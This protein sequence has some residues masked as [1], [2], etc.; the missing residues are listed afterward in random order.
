M[1]SPCHCSSIGS[2]RKAASKQIRKMENSIIPNKRSRS[3]EPSVYEYRELSDEEDEEDEEDEV[4]EDTL[5]LLDLYK[6]KLLCREMDLK[7][8]KQK[9]FMKYFWPTEDD[10]EEEDDEVEED[11]EERDD[12]EED[13]EEKEKDDEEEEDEKDDEEENEKDD[14]EEEEKD[15]EEEEE[16]DD[17]EDEKEKKDD[18]EEYD[19]EEEDEEERV[20]CLSINDQLEI[21]NYY[22]GQTYNY[23]VYCGTMYDSKTDYKNKCPGQY[24]IDHF[25]DFYNDK[26]RI[27]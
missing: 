20:Y 6:C 19:E 13:E 14:E 24:R 1:D 3:A 25:P 2:V 27:I 7:Q 11:E 26:I 15:D 9:P 8:G 22:L 10:E 23:C 4:D 18:E 16:K 21:V 17:E 12:E 5:D